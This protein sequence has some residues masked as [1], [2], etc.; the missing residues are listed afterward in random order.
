MPDAA[1]V[2]IP[3]VAASD[4][5]GMIAPE[6]TALVL[7]D[8]QNDWAAPEGLLG[9]HGVDLS[10]PHAAIDKAEELVAAARAAGV[11]LAFVRVVTTPETDSEALKTFYTRRGEPGGQV[12]CRKGY[13]AD[14][15]RLLPEPGDIEVE[16]VLYDCFHG[17]DF[18][19]QLTERGIDT[20][21]ITGLSTDCCVDAAAR[22]AFH[23]NFN[24]F[25][26]SD[27]TAAYE[28]GLHEATLK[29]LSKNCALMVTTQAAKTAW[30]Q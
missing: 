14:Y 15:Y 8:I 20:L 26:V 24:V 3:H 10:A 6:R 23:R 19:A 21:L 16:K 29:V 27:A 4:L 28:P 9:Q 17:T 13:G 11:T 18:E 12:I 30:A 5:A 22:S 1:L 25:V 7:V 2:D